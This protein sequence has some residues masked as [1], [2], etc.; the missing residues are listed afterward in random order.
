M[1]RPG[2]HHTSG[3]IQ[4]AGQNIDHIGGPRGDRAE[5]HRV[6]PDAAVYGCRRSGGDFAS[7][8]ANLF[9]GDPGAR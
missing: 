3:A 1:D 8:A 2:E 9:S 4:I 5:F 6:I 7:Q